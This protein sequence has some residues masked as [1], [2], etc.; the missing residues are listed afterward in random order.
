MATKTVKVTLTEKNDA[1]PLFD[2]FYSLNGGLSFTSSVDSTNLYLPYVGASTVANVDEGSNGYQLKS[3]G[4][5]INS[6][7]SGS[8]EP[9]PTPT[10]TTQPT[11]TPT[12]D[13][14]ITPTPTPTATTQPTPTPTPACVNF[15]Y[16]QIQKTSSTIHKSTWVGSSQAYNAFALVTYLTGQSSPTQYV[17]YA[18]LNNVRIYDSGGSSFA[19][20][21]YT[22][23]SSTVLWYYDGINVVVEITNVIMTGT[24]S[25]GLPYSDTWCYGLGHEVP[26]TPTPTPTSSPTPTATPTNTPTPTPTATSVIQSYYVDRITNPVSVTYI[27]PYFET[28]SFTHSSGYTRYIVAREIVT[29]SNATLG[30]QGYAYPNTVLDTSSLDLCN[31][32]TLLVQGGSGITYAYWLEKS[33]GAPQIGEYDTIL[34]DDDITA[35]MVSGSLMVPNID[36]NPSNTTITYLGDCDCV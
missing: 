18:L 2:L 26:P 21:S 23:I 16:H 9:T 1:G 10:A 6:V 32:D 17:P 4:V 31:A 24:Y 5:C 29:S 33:T 30:N 36:N 25:D 19:T 3:K 20:L 7:V 8:I 13:P 35:C 34:G 22:P 27:D 12:Y 11:P 15:G 28:R 14:S